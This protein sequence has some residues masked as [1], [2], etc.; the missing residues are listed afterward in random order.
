MFEYTISTYTLHI[1]CI[2]SHKPLTCLITIDLMVRTL[3]Q[4][5]YASCV[6]ASD[7]IYPSI[8]GDGVEL[9]YYP[10]L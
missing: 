5:K 10:L 9:K 7:K 1:T 8:N 2:Y 6:T 4:Q 3:R